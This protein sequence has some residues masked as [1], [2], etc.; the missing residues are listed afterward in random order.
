VMKPNPRSAKTLTDAANL[1]ALE[2]LGAG[3]FGV[4]V[5]R[6]TGSVHAGSANASPNHCTNLVDFVVPL[7]SRPSGTRKANSRIR[8]RA[9]SALSAIDTD[10]FLLECR[11]S[12]CGNNVVDPH[13]EC[14]DGNRIDG[15]ICN[16]GCQFEG[17]TPTPTS[18]RTVTPTKT[19]TGTQTPTSATS[20]ITATPTPTPTNTQSLCGNGGVDGGEDCDDGAVC[21]GGSN[22]GNACTHNSQCPGGGEC[23]AAG[24]DGCASNCS[25]ES[26]AVFELTGAVCR[27]GSSDGTPCTFQSTCV[28]GVVARPCATQSDCAAVGGTCTSECGATSRGCFAD[29]ECTAGSNSGAPCYPIPGSL[30][31][32][33]CAGGA[34]DGLPC[35]GTADCDGS[36][37]ENACGADAPAGACEP[38]SRASLGGTGMIVRIGPLVGSQEL[39]FGAPDANGIVPVAAPA[40]GSTFAPVTV[41]G[42]ACACVRGAPDAFLHGPNNSAS[43]VVACGAM[44]IANDVATAIDHNT[45]PPQTCFIGPNTGL[46]C[47]NRCAAGGTRA[48]LPCAV[49]G[50]NPIECPGGTT[51][52]HRQCHSLTDCGAL[53]A[54]NASNGPGVCIDGPVPGRACVDGSQCLE[55]GRCLGRCTAGALVGALCSCA[56]GAVCP[57]PEDCGS[58]GVCR[59]TGGQGG[60][61]CAGPPRF[62]QGGTQAGVA[63]YDSAECPGGTC[64][65]TGNFLGYC[66]SDSDCPGSVCA[67]IDDDALCTSTD[68]DPPFGSGDAACLEK[69]EYC[70]SGTNAGGDCSAAP[71]GDSHCPAGKCG[72]DCA[73]SPRHP[74]LCNS[75]TRTRFSGAGGMGSGLFLSTIQVGAI[76]NGGSCATERQCAGGT[77]NAAPCQVDEDCPSGACASAICHGFCS[78]ATTSPCLVNADCPAGGGVCVPGATFNVAC[79]GTNP[80]TECGANAVCHPVDPAKGFDGIPC[81][82]D[83][84]PSSQGVATTIPQTT[85]TGHAS[86][87]DAFAGTSSGQQLVHKSCYPSAQPGETCI[88]SSVGTPFDCSSLAGVSPSVT[89]ARLTTA[90]P[91]VDGLTGDAVLTTLMTAR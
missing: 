40:N 25:D 23:R 76:A 12:T 5:R 65:A 54:C 69:F 46:P 85:G 6:R 26:S 38:R 90:V 27:G 10:T 83:D 39:R 91:I 20:T 17:A 4:S 82:A 35:A 87:S 37:C 30:E 41:P 2:G 9:T 3:G 77:N 13:E 33:T 22:Q 48:G 80:A 73:A 63:C 28:G 34:S 75:P 8:V 45:Y 89:G 42:L 21:F 67:S 86:V 84:P 81:T 56:A 18:T 78:I 19:Q 58:D 44:P 47:H 31:A 50:L 1:A 16:R 62:C 24:G 72:T 29:G 61:F 60:G 14:D 51:N 59:V 11:P 36:P 66:D 70:T 15:D 52:A 57:N 68:P 64:P 49:T 74:G 71:A 7:K 43:G 88:T 79:S 53:N 55:D 32:G